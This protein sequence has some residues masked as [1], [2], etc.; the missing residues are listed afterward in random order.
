[1]KRSEINNNIKWAL[2]LLKKHA[3]YLPEFAYWPIDRWIENKGKLDT[4]K[5]VMLG[6]DITDYGLKQFNRTGGVLFTLRNGN[7]KDISIGVPYAEK[8]LLFKDGQGLPLHFHFTKTEDIINRAGGVLAIK[9]YNSLPDYDIDYKSDII[10]YMDGMKRTVKPDEVIKINPGGSITIKPY[11]Y[12]IFWSLEGKGDLVAGE[13]SSV[14][15][16]DM[17]NRFYEKVP[18]YSSI[19]ED[20]PILYPLAVDYNNIMG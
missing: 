6:W 13:V 9:L 2:D 1:M 5:K 10:V 19:E 18:R 14:N 11:I 3:V 8:Y 20:E 12:H 16:D 17:D 4:I 7:Q 15:D